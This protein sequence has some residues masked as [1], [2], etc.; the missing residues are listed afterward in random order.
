MMTLQLVNAQEEFG[1]DE[2]LFCNTCH[3]E[4]FIWSPVVYSCVS[5]PSHSFSIQLCHF[6]TVHHKG[7]VRIGWSPS[8]FLTP[9][10]KSRFVTVIT[11]RKD[12]HWVPVNWLL[13]PSMQVYKGMG[14]AEWS[15]V[16]FCSFFSCCQDC[17]NCLC[18]WSLFGATKSIWLNILIMPKAF[19]HRLSLS[20]ASKVLCHLLTNPSSIHSFFVQSFII[21]SL[22]TYVCSVLYWEL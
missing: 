12:L 2:V 13:L 21:Y 20:L 4:R 11:S 22:G 6:L 14:V 5:F 3:L 9:L 17:A 10:T 19:Y 7:K 18:S 16:L 8:R 15:G 1:N